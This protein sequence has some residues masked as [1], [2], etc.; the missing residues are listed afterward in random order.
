[1]ASAESKQSLR[2][3]EKSY[4][5]GRSGL[6]LLHCHGAGIAI[7]TFSQVLAPNRGVH[8]RSNVRPY[9]ALSKEKI[10]SR[11]VSRAFGIQD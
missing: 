4:G 6:L 3:F 1:M 11:E 9:G 10:T 5:C 7:S 2:G 8:K